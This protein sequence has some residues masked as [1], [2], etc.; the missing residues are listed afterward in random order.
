MTPETQTQSIGQ[1]LDDLPDEPMRIYAWRL[2]RLERAGFSV[3][4]AVLLAN[5]KRVDVQRA[6]AMREAGCSDALV[7]E[8]LT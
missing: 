4:P 8:I 6:C 1:I 3:A 7:V 5:D 2:Y